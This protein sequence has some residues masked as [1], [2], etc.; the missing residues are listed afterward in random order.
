VTTIY[1]HDYLMF[2]TRLKP[3]YYQGTLARIMVFPQSDNP[4]QG[5]YKERVHYPHHPSQKQCRAEWD[6]GYEDQN[7]VLAGYKEKTE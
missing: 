3:Y 5:Q 6:R 1:D 7:M 4:Y 2:R